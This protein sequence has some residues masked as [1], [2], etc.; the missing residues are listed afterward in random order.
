MQLN[1]AEEDASGIKQR[2][3]KKAKKNNDQNLGEKKAIN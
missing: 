3:E 1:N 2:K